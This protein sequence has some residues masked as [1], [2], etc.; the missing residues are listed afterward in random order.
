MVK[1]GLY[2]ASNKYLQFEY[3]NDT[4]ILFLYRK[5]LNNVFYLVYIFHLIR[6]NCVIVY[7][8]IDSNL[9]PFVFCLFEKD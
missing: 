5:V 1:L 7:N 8:Y 6:Y 9:I 3:I 4:E 2:K